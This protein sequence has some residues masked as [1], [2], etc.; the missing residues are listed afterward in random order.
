VT[1]QSAIFHKFAHT[2][3]VRRAPCLCVA[4]LITPQHPDFFRTQGIEKERR[5]RSR[6][7]LSP[8]TGGAAFLGEF[9]KQ[10]WM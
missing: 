10:A 7:K 1:K 2:K 5:M 8:L 4:L 3:Q 9:W 6:K